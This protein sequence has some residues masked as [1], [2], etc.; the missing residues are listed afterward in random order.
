MIQP[1]V[2]SLLTQSVSPQEVGA[3]LGLGAAFLSLGN[4]V[5][6]LWGGAAFDFITPGAPFM[7]GGVIIAMLVPLAMRRV[8]MPEQHEAAP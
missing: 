1:S 5:G 3:T 4:I 8:T 2:N 6:P 7:I